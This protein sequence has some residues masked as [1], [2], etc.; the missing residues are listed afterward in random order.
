M[1]ESWFSW[2][3]TLS[4]LGLSGISLRTLLERRASCMCLEEAVWAKQ[5]FKF[6]AA[7]AEIVWK[8]R[9]PLEFYC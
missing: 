5:L 6:A 2:G 8:C 4:R 3:V 1:A 7:V 9:E